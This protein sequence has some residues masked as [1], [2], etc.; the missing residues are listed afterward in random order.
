MKKN[1]LKIFLIVI[2]LIVSCTRETVHKL[3]HKPIVEP[4]KEIPIE[5]GN[6]DWNKTVHSIIGGTPIDINGDKITE[7]FVGGGQ[8][9]DDMLFS[10]QKNKFRNIING[11]GLSDT[12]A[13][14]GANSLDID[15]DGD[16]DLILARSNGIFLYLNKNGKFLKTPLP[17]NFPSNS[18][19]FNVAV[20]DIDRD[21]D[22]D[23]YIS[24][25]VDL[26]SFKSAT[27]N[28]SSHAKTNIMLLNNGDLTFTDITTSSKTASLQNTFL[29]SFI[30]LNADGWLDL[31]VSQNT[32]QVEIFQ[33]L[34]NNSFAAKKLTTGWG[35]WMGLAVGD[36]DYDGDQDLF[37][38]N[39]GNSIPNFLLEIAGDGLDHQ[40]RNYSWILLRNDGN[41]N[42]TNITN[43]YQL[44]DYGFAW[45]AVFE[46]LTL[47]GSL[48]LLV[49]QNYIKWFVHKF[50][51]LS[52]KSF[53]LHDSA[54]YHVPELGLENYDFSQSPVIF[55][56]NN[57]GKPDVFWINMDGS[58]KIARAFIN[59][60]T[61][62]FITV[63][64]KD[65]VKSI[66]AKV[67]IE[68]EDGK[69]YTRE[70]L[71]NLGFSTDQF[72]RLTFGIGKKTKILQVVIQWLDGSKKIIKN[73]RIN[74]IVYI[75]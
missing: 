44:E 51:K 49:A 47:N 58:K 26:K 74:Q 48:E 42:F 32:G 56:F 15:N 36:I 25:F 60:S 71:N 28:D 3:K 8:G 41:F 73:P 2:I 13:T 31:V 55:D 35:F 9:H 57:D 11:T 64:F 22:G 54:F 7:I 68:T 6:N 53:I 39:S 52:S 50:S 30:D 24:V 43:K 63:A 34:K 66:G 5:I 23:L 18:T 16:I 27:Y 21:G 29:A 70:I 1:K 12:M 10:Y 69:S 59:Q 75:D 17:V 40:P 45:G 4:F 61:N 72:S 65:N 62:N 33:N 14:H 38:T 19:A 37:F 67:F 20:G 46:D